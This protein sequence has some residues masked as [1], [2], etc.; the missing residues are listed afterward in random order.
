MEKVRIV[1][2]YLDG[3]MVKGFTQNFAPNKPS[4]H[5]FPSE[6]AD[7]KETVEIFLRELKAVFF[8]RDFAGRPDYNERKA[9]SSGERPSGRVVEVTF[10]D[11]EVL[12]GSTLGYDPKKPGFFL[13]PADPQ[14]NNARVFVISRAVR[15][16]RYL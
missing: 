16:V 8:V 15:V 4:F 11:G 3:R 9:Y 7:P 5:I 13:F 12:V 6:A 1:A 2:R 14:S 10:S